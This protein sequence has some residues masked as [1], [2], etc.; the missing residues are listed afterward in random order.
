MIINGNDLARH[1]YESLGFQPYETF[2]AAY[3]KEQF[4]LDF[5][6]VTKFGLRLNLTG[7]DQ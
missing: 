5:P 2:H 3:F 4:D 7:E 6:G 1:T